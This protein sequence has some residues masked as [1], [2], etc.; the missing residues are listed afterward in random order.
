M[1]KFDPKPSH[2]PE[3]PNANELLLMAARRFEDLFDGVPVA[4]L[5]FD[6]AANIFEW[7]AAAEELWERPA[8]EAFQKPL[9]WAARIEQ[10]VEAIERLLREVRSGNP[11]RDLEWSIE[12]DDGRRKWV[13]VNAFPLRNPQG[14]ISGGVLS[15]LDITARIEMQKQLEAH[16]LKNNEN[17]VM[18][19]LQRDELEAAN[20]QL[21]ALA[22]T[23]GLTGLNNHRSFQEFLER[24]CQIA[25]RS[26]DDLSL[27][28][29]DVDKFKSLNDNYGHPAGDE[30]LRRVAQVLREAARASDYVARYGGEEFVVVLTATNADGAIEAAERF[31]QALEKHSFPMGR[32]T[33]SFGCA[34]FFAYDDTREELIARADAALYE[35]KRTGRNRSV[36]A[37]AMPHA[38]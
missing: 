26:R 36:H 20:A 38:A 6:D 30:V 17:Q 27:V 22:T 3:P 18:L 32:V 10:K 7:N 5:T 35:A 29:L 9:G 19:E 34:T 13:T 14:A 24:Q 23:D 1:G 21:Q 15:A 16:I 37:D 25:K 11:V 31:R 33:A 2:G 12:F 8:A 4:C 28:L